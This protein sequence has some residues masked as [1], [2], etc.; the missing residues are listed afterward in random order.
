MSIL[1][2]RYFSLCGR[3]VCLC[4]SINNFQVLQVFKKLDTHTQ[5]LLRNVLY[6]IAFQ[7]VYTETNVYPVHNCLL[8][9]ISCI[10]KKT[11]CIVNE[12][13]GIISY[14]ILYVCVCVCGVWREP[15]YPER[16]IYRYTTHTHIHTYTV[17]ETL[18]PPKTKVRDNISTSRLVIN[19]VKITRIILSHVPR[20]KAGQ[21]TVQSFYDN[22]YSCFKDII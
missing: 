21:S 10:Q 5:R 6:Y 15:K 14:I 2:C 11:Q 4:I 9:N 19:D 17:K 22:H 7:S 1:L 18:F 16:F 13:L 12:N 3:C 20:D 8:I